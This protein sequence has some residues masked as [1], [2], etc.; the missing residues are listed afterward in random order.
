VVLE[1]AIK[2]EMVKIK[3]KYLAKKIF[4]F[5]KDK[6]ANCGLPRSSRPALSSLLIF[7]QPLQ[8]PTQSWKASLKEVNLHK[9]K[10]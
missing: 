4:L 2:G 5:I 6:L 10:L 8:P 7:R 9:N 1:E 3:S